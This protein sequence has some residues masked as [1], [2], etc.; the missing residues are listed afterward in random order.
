MIIDSSDCVPTS[1]SMDQ[2][3][4]PMDVSFDWNTNDVATMKKIIATLDMALFLSDVYLEWHATL[5]EHWERY[6]FMVGVSQLLKERLVELE[7]IAEND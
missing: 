1:I 5:P 2:L 7:L 3:D 4:F 6:L